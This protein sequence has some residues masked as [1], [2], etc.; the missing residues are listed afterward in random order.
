MAE[1]DRF[2]WDQRYANE[3]NRVDAPPVWLEEVDDDIPRNGSALDIAAGS[4]RVALWLAARGLEVTA[5]DIS[6]VGLELVLQSAKAKGVHIESLRADLEVDPLPD[7]PFDVIT[8]FHYR[9]VD[10]FPFIRERLR[11]GGVLIAEMAT[12]SNLERHPHPSL[13][14]LSAAGE[15]RLICAPLEIVHY[16]ED[17]FNDHALA[18]VM[19]R[20]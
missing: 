15:L 20:K 7:G 13:R 12:V 18:R 5:V 9:Q 8:C 16:Q 1:S 14:Y 3:S 17:W 19:A 4:G 10:L 2:R 11:F 6:S